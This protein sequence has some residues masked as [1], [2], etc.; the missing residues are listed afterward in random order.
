MNKIKY[1][2]SSGLSLVEVLLSIVILSVGISALM[3]ATNKCLVVLK[4]A[5]NRDIAYNLIR[6]IDTDYP[7]QKNE[8]DEK[9]E[10]G[11][12]K[13]YDD[14]TWER[15]ILFEDFEKTPGLFLINLT[16][17]WSEKGNV[18]NE[19]ISYYIYAPEAESVSRKI[20]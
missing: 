17:M 20:N 10:S 19:K 9:I 4:R 13:N 7:I 6:Q 12:F 2:K 8:L 18:S 15:E 11:S 1:K 3:I 5:Q 16:V 14:F